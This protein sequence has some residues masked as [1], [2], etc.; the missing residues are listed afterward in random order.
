MA[1]IL[2]SQSNSR[3]GV[4]GGGGSSSGGLIK[5]PNLKT[6]A[7]LEDVAQRSGLENQAANIKESLS[8]ET[9]NKLYSGGFISDIFDTLN[10]LQHGVT[11]VIKGKG[12]VEGMK[13]RQS[14]SDKDALGQYGL[15]G[16][17]AGVGLDI[18][19]DPL[20]YVAPGAV[21][22]RIPGAEKGAV[23]AAKAFGE[24]K[25][26]NMVYSA[27][28]NRFGQDP[29]YQK[30]AKR[31]IT[32]INVG[33]QNMLDLVRP[34]TKLNA[35]AQR[36]I[37]EAR[38]AGTLESLPPEL[39]EKAKPAFDELDRLGR[40]A[41]EAGLLD[42]DTYEKNVGTYIRRLYTSKEAP[43]GIES[44]KT[45]FGAKPQ[46]IDV[47]PFMKRD[48]IPEDVRE[49]MGEI[50]EAGYPTAKGLVQLKTAIEKS[51]FFKAVSE[52]FSSDVAQEGFTKLAVSS[53]LGALS[54]R[55]VPEFVSKDL[56]ELSQR[57]SGS[58]ELGKKIVAG[59]KFA[60][61]VLNPA[62]HARNIMSNLVLNNF[63]GL[64]PGRI[65]IYAQAAKELATKGKFYEEAK[66]LGLGADTFATAELRSILNSSEVKT[67]LGK[68]TN[69]G[70]QVLDRISTLYQKEEEFAKMAQYIYQRKKGLSTE[71]AWDITERATFNYAEVTPF[72]RKLRESLW[73][74]PFITFTYKATPQI[75]KTA[76]KNPGR[77][78]WIG[79]LKEGI[80]NQSDSDELAREREAEPPWVKDGYFVK[81]PIKDDQGRSAYLDLTYIIPFGD[82]VSGNYFERPT[83]RDTGL[84]QDVITSG[85]QKL[86]V[87][88]LIRELTTN[89]DFYGKAIVKKSSSVD[90]QIADITRHIMKTYLPP[91]IAEQIPSGYEP[92]GERRAGNISRALDVE[93]AEPDEASRLSQRN[94]MQEMLRYAGMKIQPIDAD[95][96]EEYAE[97][98]LEK[99]Y[100][101]LLEEEGELSGFNILFEPDDE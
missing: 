63:E 88:N 12:F 36:S 1:G 95:I 13:T 31:S 29:V 74:A 45:M 83:D 21:I 44:L 64:S 97:N 82:V 61:V 70:R 99:A 91:P 38:K 47:S 84:P 57:L 14:F 20:T 56:D 69:A 34:L 18:A 93:N 90:Q 86:P 17:V 60:K 28:V 89:Q 49:A 98:T 27:L 10:A 15:P 25:M 7:G 73:G 81:L 39:L 96:Q 87:F 8:G 92:S 68:T 33:N 22:R 66:Q 43:D 24:T 48:D 26:G 78:S 37:A 55:Y 100:K 50:M 79:K 52:G 42:L 40:E 65:D 54:G 76:Y 2:E 71:E 9:P 11:G 51:K 4:L 5:K 101:T 32:N 72:I 62:T 23:A 35:E 94:I 67:A 6:S 16:M 75:A 30:L 3:R 41:V 46:R 85:A 80:E 19:F 58:D 77:I 53:R 59:F